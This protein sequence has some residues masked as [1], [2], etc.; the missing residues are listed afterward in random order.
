MHTLRFQKLLAFLNTV[1]LS[2]LISRWFPYSDDMEDE[3]ASFYQTSTGRT[4]TILGRSQRKNFSFNF[5]DKHE[6][7]LV[8]PPDQ[9]TCAICDSHDPRKLSV[10]FLCK[11]GKW[12][13]FTVLLSLNP[14]SRLADFRLSGE[15][16][17]L[18][19]RTLAGNRGYPEPAIQTSSQVFHLTAPWGADRT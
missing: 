16:R 18:I 4:L 5:Y 9:R 19:S 12:R 17:G 15:E 6:N 10:F 13:V 2:L 8:K 14:E 7:F 1:R 11:L 3:E